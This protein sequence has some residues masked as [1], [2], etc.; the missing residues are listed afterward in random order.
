VIPS[1]KKPGNPG[2]FIFG[3]SPSATVCHLKLEHF[4]N[5]NLGVKTM[6]ATTAVWLHEAR[7]D[8]AEVDQAVTKSGSMTGGNCERLFKVY[9][10]AVKAPVVEKFHSV[11]GSYQTH[12]LSKL[13]Q[14]YGLWTMLPVNL[15]SGITDIAPFYPVYPREAAYNTLVSSSS[16]SV[17]ENRI[18]VA[19][20]LLNYVEK[21]VIC[22]TVAFAKLKL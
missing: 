12:D 9:E 15:Q 4:R 18:A 1:K 17:W 19:T 6:N 16:V 14:S 13:C 21:N 5:S 2:F 10:K 7:T 11:P 3:L 22:D 20:E 8:L